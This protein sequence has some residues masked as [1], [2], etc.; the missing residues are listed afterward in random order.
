MTVI[1]ITFIFGY[2]SVDFLYAYIHIYIY[3]YISG[4]F[5]SRYGT[6]S[7]ANYVT[8]WHVTHRKFYVTSRNVT[9]NNMTYHVTDHHATEKCHHGT[10]RSITARPAVTA[11]NLE[12]GCD[13][14]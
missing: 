14:P 10:S 2:T 7:R 13:L 12:P 4:V 3:I 1:V 6:S 5:L 9:Q 8:A 11:P